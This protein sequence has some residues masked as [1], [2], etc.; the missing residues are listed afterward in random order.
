[1]FP[2]R[3]WRRIGG[4]WNPGPSPEPR[5]EGAEP[6]QEPKVWI[7]AGS[8]AGYEVP[9]G[10]AH[11][12]T[13]RPF[14]TGTLSGVCLN[15]NARSGPPEGAASDRVRLDVQMAVAQMLFALHE[16][17]TDTRCACGLPLGED[18]GLCYYGR[19]AQKQIMETQAEIRERDQRRGGA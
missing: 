12:Y 5:R 15:S 4:P 11:R 1:M 6:S 10:E 2:P 9:Q 8:G 18:T 16:P 19:V 17:A 14:L 3:R 13:A 7:D